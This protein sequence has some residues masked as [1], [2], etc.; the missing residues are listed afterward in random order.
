MDNQ[1]NRALTYVGWLAVCVLLAYVLATLFQ[2]Y[3]DPGDL[4]LQRNKARKDAAVEKSRLEE[5]NDQKEEP[6]DA[7]VVNDE[8]T[9]STEFVD[10]FEPEPSTTPDITSFEALLQNRVDSVRATLSGGRRRTDVII[11]YYPHLPDGEMVYELGELGFYLHERPTDS[12]QVDVPTNSVYY[13]DNVPLKDIQL[14][15]Y[16]LLKKGVKIRQ[17]KMSRFH[18]DWKANSIEIGTDTSVEDQPVLTWGDVQKFR[19]AAG[20]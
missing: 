17:I 18:D 4:L 5:N 15:T 20:N 1:L 16:E 10:P 12:S 2:G 14:V 6:S 7:T 3:T 9:T 13:G 8:D 11:R 19:K